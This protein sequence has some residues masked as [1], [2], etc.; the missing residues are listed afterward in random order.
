MMEASIQRRIA[1]RGPGKGN[2]KK[3]KKSKKKEAPPLAESAKLDSV[4]LESYRIIDDTEGIVT[5]YLMAVY[6]LL[7]EGMKLR[8]FVQKTWQDVAYCGLNSATAGAITNMAIAMTQRTETA[9]FVDFPGHESY[10][11]VLQTI[12]RGN[13]QWAKTNFGDPHGYDTRWE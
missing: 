2:K 5:D 6:S 7:E 3:G 10:E 4:P 13:M 8:S 9:I 12:S 1:R 11:T